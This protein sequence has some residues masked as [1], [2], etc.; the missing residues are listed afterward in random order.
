MKTIVTM[1]VTM[2][3]MASIMVTIITLMRPPMAGTA[4]YD[5]I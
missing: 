4:S 1:M 5:D 2:V 3:T